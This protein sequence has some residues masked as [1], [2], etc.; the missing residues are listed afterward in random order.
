M[1]ADLHLHTNFSD[2]TYS[3]EELVGE[4]RKFGLSV[5]A[6]TDHDTVEGCQRMQK[7]CADSSIEFIPASEL[8]AEYKGNE[9]HLL[10]YFLNTEHPRLLREM[11]H[12][13]DVRQ[14][15][16]REMVS[17]LNKINIPLEADAVF[18]IANCRSPG[19]PHV[20]RALVQGGYCATL[21]EAFERFLKKNRPAW[22]PKFRISAADAIG[23]IHEAGG[24]A[25]MAHP[26]LNRSDDIIPAL[27]AAG[28]DGLECYHTKHTLTMTE[29][30][31]EIARTHKLVVTGGSDCHGMNKGKPLIG[32]I[33]LPYEYVRRMKARLSSPHDGAAGTRSSS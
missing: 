21:D 17:R 22:V 29:R 26:G 11:A 24:L 7:A 5:L 28:L 20:G 16:I 25:V 3:P 1:F 14:N 19:R 15:R 12:F 10:G 8:T 32:G 2:G 30:Y 27:V 13:Q 33:K 6:L 31:L 4:A 9:L 23:L 18:A